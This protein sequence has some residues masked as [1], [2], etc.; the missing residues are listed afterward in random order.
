MCETEFFNYAATKIIYRNRLNAGA[1][2]R[3]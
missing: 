3:I 1:D 2:F